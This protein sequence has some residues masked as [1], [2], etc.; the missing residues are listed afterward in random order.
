MLER[1]SECADPDNSADPVIRSVWNQTNGEAFIGVDFDGVLVEFVEWSGHTSFGRPIFSMVERV[2]QMLKKGK[3]VKIFTA[4]VH[5]EYEGADEVRQE[6]EKW[7][8]EHLGQKLE[9]TAMKDFRM[10]EFWDDRAVG[11]LINSGNATEDILMA[12]FEAVVRHYGEDYDIKEL[13]EYSVW[14]E[15]V[16]HVL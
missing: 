3:R 2:Q 10:V 1:F 8:E 9:C 15:E 14:S 6:I 5:P 4:R 16:N 12:E 7:C 11:V 13:K